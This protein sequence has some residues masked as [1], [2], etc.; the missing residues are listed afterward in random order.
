MD[1]SWQKTLPVIV[2]IIIIIGVAWLRDYSKTFAA[3]VATMPLNAPLALWI[4][5]TG[6]DT[7]KA[8]M[9]QFTEAMVINI[10]PT[11]AWLVI[12]WLAARAGWG[13]IPMLVVGYA[14]WAVGLG[15]VFILRQ[16]V[17]G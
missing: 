2:S 5:S 13:L 14:A 10:W 1:I 3:I 12:V 9:T 7:D 6:G 4:I 8:G 16:A 17:G 11:I 15:I